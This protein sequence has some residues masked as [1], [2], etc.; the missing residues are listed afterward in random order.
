M[1]QE[2]MKQEI[3]LTFRM[4][5]QPLLLCGKSADGELWSTLKENKY[6]ESRC[7][8]NKQFTLSRGQD[9]MLSYDI[10]RQSHQAWIMSCH[11]YV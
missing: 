9:T 2:K 4:T 7:H 1:L 3:F 11:W 10:T 5:V 8:L 6:S